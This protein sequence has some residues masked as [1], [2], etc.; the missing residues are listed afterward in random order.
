MWAIISQFLGVFG[1]G[2]G[3]LFSYAVQWW[4]NRKA[5]ESAAENQMKQDIQDHSGDGQ[6]SVGEVSSAQ[7]QLNDIDQQLSDIDNQSKT[8]IKPVPGGK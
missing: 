5:A 1:S 3:S 2:L 7:Q 8:V 4:E 6:I